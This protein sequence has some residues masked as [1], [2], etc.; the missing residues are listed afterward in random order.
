MKLFPLLSKEKC[1]S[2]VEIAGAGF[3]NFFVTN[4]FYEE[5][6]KDVLN[7]KRIIRKTRYKQR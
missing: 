6:V 5:I 2:K 1:F 7:K 3:I 4:S